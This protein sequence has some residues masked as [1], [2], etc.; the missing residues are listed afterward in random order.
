VVVAQDALVAGDIT[1]VL[2][3]TRIEKGTKV[4]GDVTVVGGVFHRHPEAIISGDITN[5]QSKVLVL[6]I[7]AGVGI[8]LGSIVMLIRWLVQR[9]RKRTFAAA[10]S[11][12]LS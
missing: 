12:N 6:L 11:G 9:S 4:G 8:V 3:D 7:M 1:T 5:L 2:G 10:S